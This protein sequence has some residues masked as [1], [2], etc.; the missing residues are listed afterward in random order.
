[1][2]RRDDI[3]EEEELA[4]G[5]LVLLRLHES[6]RRVRFERLSHDPVQVFAAKDHLSHLNLT[7]AEAAE[8]GR[9]VVQRLRAR[10]LVDGFPATARVSELDTLDAQG[11][12]SS[13]DLGGRRI[14]DCP[15]ARE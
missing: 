1:M 11:S 13:D 14:G 8:R 5:T 10:E 9:R 15:G 3:S 4:E 6:L 12:G 2:A 7:L